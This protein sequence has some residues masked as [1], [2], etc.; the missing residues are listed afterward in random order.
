MARRVK[1]STLGDERT[2]ARFE[3]GLE[4]A[5]SE[6]MSYWKNRLEEILPDKPDLIVLPECCDRFSNFTTEQNTA[7]YN[8]RGERFLD[9]F[10]EIAKTNNCY[11]AYSSIMPDTDGINRNSVMMIDR[12]GNVMGRYNKHYLVTGEIERINGL[13]GNKATIF[14]CDF[15]RV[16]A[17]ICFDLNFEEI[18]K[19]YK[20]EKPEIMIFS[21]A[22][23]G[24]FMQQYWA[25]ELRSWFVSAVGCRWPSWFVN[26]VGT[27]ISKTSNYTLSQTEEINLDYFVAHYDDNWEALKNAKNKY[28][29][30]LRIY[31]PDMIGAVLLTSESD[32]ISINEMVEDFG[33]EGIDNYFKRSIKCADEHREC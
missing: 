27:I 17:A 10:A 28:K 16:G 33:I 11:I 30:A 12:N 1:V 19:L 29:D 18:L 31:D 21:S 32:T 22:Y 26:P 24:G 23:H 3:D 9:F 5:L 4:N 6:K 20:K 25:Y 7:Y 13:C 14:E 2:Y 8:Y 15:G